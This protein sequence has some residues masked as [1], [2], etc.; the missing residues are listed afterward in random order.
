[1][2]DRFEYLLNIG[3]GILLLSLFLWPWARGQR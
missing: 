2:S 3:F 1:M